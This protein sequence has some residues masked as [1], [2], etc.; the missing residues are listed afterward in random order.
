MPVQYKNLAGLNTDDIQNGVGAAKSIKL[1]NLAAASQDAAAA[2]NEGNIYYDATSSSLKLSDGTN[3]S[4]VIFVARPVID[5]PNT[6]NAVTAATTDTIYTIATA[7]PGTD[8]VVNLDA[9]VTVGYE[10]TFSMGVDGGSDIVVTCGGADVFH[11]S[12]AINSVTATMADLG[13]YLVI[14]KVRPD[15]WLVIADRGNAYA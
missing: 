8:T 14:R 9:G 7:A 1:P 3:W 5:V 12:A 11:H 4:G 15:V 13:D 6:T 2:A 10:L